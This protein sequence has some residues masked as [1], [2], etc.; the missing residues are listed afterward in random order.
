MNNFTI[1]DMDIQ[2]VDG[3]VTIENLSF[4]TPWTREALVYDITQNRCAKYRVILMDERVV[5]YGG[6]W[7]MLDEAH[8]TNIA[9]HPEFRGMGF[10]NEI[11]KDIINCAINSGV[12]DMTLEVRASNIAAINLYNKFGFQEV[13]IRRGYYQDTN[14]DA[15]IMWKYDINIIE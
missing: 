2:H 6:M 9:V 12:K 13:A 5:A 4:K 7:V 3:V 14:E 1:C 11:M 8:I 10:G 15:I